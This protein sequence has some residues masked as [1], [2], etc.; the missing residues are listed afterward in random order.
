MEL[1]LALSIEFRLWRG[2]GGKACGIEVMGEL[3]MEFR[4]L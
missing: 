3:P 2:A 1:A 4:R